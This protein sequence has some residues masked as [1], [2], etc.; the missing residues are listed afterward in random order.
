MKEDCREVQSAWVGVSSLFSSDTVHNIQMTIDD[1]NVFLPKELQTIREDVEE[2]CRSSKW[3]V[4][5]FAR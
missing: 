4:V 2:D 5:E 3:S 1:D